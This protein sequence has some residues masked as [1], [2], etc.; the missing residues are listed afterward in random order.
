MVRPP[1][2][3]SPD[4]VD[5][6]D[7]S[8]HPTTSRSTKPNLTDPSDQPTHPSGP[9][10]E[11]TVIHG[12]LGDYLRESVLPQ[13]TGPLWYWAART[14]VYPHLAVA[15]RNVLCIPASSGPSERVFSMSVRMCNPLRGRLKGDIAEVLMHVRCS[16]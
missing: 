9:E 6:D 3:S 16:V 12:E 15:T 10:E 8:D 4:R 5:V 14:A 1:R 13:D 2:T 11:K 7:P